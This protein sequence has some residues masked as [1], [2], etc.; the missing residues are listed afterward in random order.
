MAASFRVIALGFIFSGLILLRIPIWPDHVF[1]DEIRSVKAGSGFVAG[2][3]GCGNIPAPVG[4]GYGVDGAKRNLDTTVQEADTA[5]IKQRIAE[6]NL[7]AS[8]VRGHFVENATPLD[9]GVITSLT[10]DLPDECLFKTAVVRH[11]ADVVAVTLPDLER[12]FAG[13][14]RMRP[15]VVL[16]FDVTPDAQVELV[17]CCDLFQV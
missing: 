16:G 14:R 13:K 8:Q 1:Q 7:A 10:F 4:I 6:P 2:D 17:D 11:P 15:A 3:K 9:G 12:C 5:G